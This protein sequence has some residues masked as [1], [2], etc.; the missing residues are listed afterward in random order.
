MARGNTSRTAST[1]AAIAQGDAPPPEL[2]VARIPRSG[3]AVTHRVLCCGAARPRRSAG[4]RRRVSRWRA[5]S[6]RSTPGRAS[7]SAIRA[8]CAARSS[9]STSERRGRRVARVALERALAAPLDFVYGVRNRQ[10]GVCRGDAERRSKRAC[11]ISRSRPVRLRRAGDAGACSTPA[12]DLAAGELTLF[13]VLEQARAARR[14]LE[15]ARGADAAGSGPPSRTA[16]ARSIS[17]SW[18]RA[19]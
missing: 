9:A 8:R 12:A 13:D 2:E 6:R 7:C 14:L 19:S 4:L 3:T 10:R 5:P 16:T 18:R 11:S 1:L 17:R 15:T